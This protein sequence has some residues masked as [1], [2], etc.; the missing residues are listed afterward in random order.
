[1]P[2][3]PAAIVVDIV[4][5]DLGAVTFVGGV[6]AGCAVVIDGASLA[7]VRNPVVATTSFKWHDH[8]VTPRS[9]WTL[10]MAPPEAG[11]KARNGKTNANRSTLSSGF[12]LV[13]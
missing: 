3:V 12:S 4:G 2:G 1:M 7:V 9:V 6:V 13:P 5:G 10:V 8:P 11:A